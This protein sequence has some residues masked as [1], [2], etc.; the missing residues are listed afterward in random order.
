[1]SEVLR[2]IENGNKIFLCLNS[3]PT[4]GSVKSEFLGRKTT[5]CLEKRW[6]WIFHLWSSGSC[7]TAH[8]TS[9]KQDWL[10]HYPLTTL[11][12]TAMGLSSLSKIP[13][14]LRTACGNRKD[15][16]D[17]NWSFCKS[18]VRGKEYKFLSLLWSYFIS[19]LVLHMDEWEACIFVL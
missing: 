1:M 6:K 5:F 14:E 12:L 15:Y 11:D 10:G 4:G 2:L 3:K 7:Y 16:D 19:G 13:P 18:Q 9:S 17:G 8:E